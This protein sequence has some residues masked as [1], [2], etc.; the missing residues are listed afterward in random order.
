MQI[1]DW[2]VGGELQKTLSDAW[3]RMHHDEPNIS[4]FLFPRSVRVL[5]FL[6]YWRPCLT[7]V[8]SLFT[9]SSQ[10]VLIWRE[11]LQEWVN[12]YPASWWMP[13]QDDFNRWSW[14]DFE[15]VCCTYVKSM[16]LD[17]TSASSELLWTC[18]NVCTLTSPWDCLQVLYLIIA[19]HGNRPLVKERTW[20][21]QIN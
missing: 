12:L 10:L 3:I 20:S 7:S 2:R 9:I 4:I 13:S 1:S 15:P 14:S 5:F 21:F 19:E 6:G 18:H 8:L 17:R 11:L 16:W